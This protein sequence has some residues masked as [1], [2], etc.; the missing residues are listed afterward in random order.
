MPFR[1]L[2]KPLIYDPFPWLRTR[3]DGSVPQ[4]FLYH[5]QNVRYSMSFFIKAAFRLRKES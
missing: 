2:C 5:F 1:I 4:H 3:P